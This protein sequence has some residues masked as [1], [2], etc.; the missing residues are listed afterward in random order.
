MAV[1]VYPG[2]FD[3]VTNGHI[4]ILERMSGVFDKIIVAV[5]HNVTKQALFTL[6]ERVELI[7]ESTKH[8]DNVEVEGFNGLLAD[9]LKEKN[10]VVI[11]RGLRSITDFEYESHMSMMN[12]LLLPEVNT[13]FVMSDPQYIFV[14]SSGVKEAALLGGDV[15]RLVP[16]AVEKSLLEKYRAGKS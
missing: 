8:L 3:P 2:S 16:A 12:K 6:D 4:D 10:V 7:K 13:I 11:I 1:A 14:S 9:F 15:K 5:V